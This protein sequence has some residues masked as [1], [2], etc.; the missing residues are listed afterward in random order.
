MA[1]GSTAIPSTKSCNLFVSGEIDNLIEGLQEV[2]IHSVV[3]DKPLTVS[4]DLL[5]DIRSIDETLASA[6]IEQNTHLDRCNHDND[7]TKHFHTNDRMLTYKRIQ[8]QFFTDTFF[9]Y[10][11]SQVQ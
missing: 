10:K 3:M 5:S 7:L 6:A 4:A 1:I 11:E 8:S 2:E 9:C